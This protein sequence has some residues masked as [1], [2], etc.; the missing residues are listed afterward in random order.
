MQSFKKVF[1]AFLTLISVH[2]YAANKIICYFNNPVNTSISSGVNAV[3]LNNCMADTLIA[4][5]NRAKYSIDIAQY[6]YVQGSYSNIAT[7]INSAYAR[8]VRVRWIYDGSASNS[9]V[10]L[11]NS[12]IHTLGSPTTS[13]YGIMHN[14]FVIIDNGSSN[15]DDAIV[16]TGSTDWNR[17][18]F[19]SDFNNVIIFQDS[20]L[21][22][23]YTDE[24]NM[25]WGDTSAT[26]NAANSKFGPHKTD[27]GRH[28]FNIDGKIVELYFSP[29][30]GTETHIQ[31]TIATADKDL[32]FGM[33]TFTSSADASQIIAR[34]TAG[35][36]VA[37]IEDQFSDT[38]SPYTMFTSALGSNFKLYSNSFTIYHNKYLIVDP[39]DACSDPMVLTGSHNWSTSANT[40][41]DENT[42]IVHDAFIA[43][44]YLQAFSAD[45]SSLGGSLTTV[46]GCTAGVASQSTAQDAITIFPNPASTNFKL[47]IP[48]N[49]A[50]FVSVYLINSLGQQSNIFNKFW[51][52]NGQINVPVPDFAPGFYIVKTVAGDKIYYSSVV[53]K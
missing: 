28:T 14:K 39:S 23:A 3:Y 29:S 27:L 45:F 46:G 20:A 21:A 1:F 11:L 16:Y 53:L 19:I 47:S 37:G 42:V 5:I 36:Y 52:E 34:Q 18:Q 40:Q 7:A 44:E 43:N 4:Y 26:P 48:Q 25:M 24:F 31:S 35:V 12:G 32:Y 30:D 13:G 10:S 15:P 2:C 17:T 22:H 38:Y 33:Y 41:N 51:L 50:Q 8:G 6:E 49:G 9:G